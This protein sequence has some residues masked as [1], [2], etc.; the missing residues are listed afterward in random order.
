VYEHI[1]TTN[2]SNWIN[3][4][5]THNKE[6]LWLKDGRALVKFEV[7]RIFFVENNQN[8]ERRGGVGV[9]IDQWVAYIDYERAMIKGWKSHRIKFKALWKFIFCTKTQ[10]PKHWEDGSSYK[11]PWEV[12]LQ[13]MHPCQG[14]ENM[15]KQ[16]WSWWK[17]VSVLCM[18]CFV[19]HRDIH[20]PVAVACAD[21]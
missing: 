5:C 6:S 4:L 18:S 2:M 12:K 19:F 10:Q 16:M 21:A 9:S 8:I 14:E 15:K 7:L 1:T 20:R 17:F 13:A 11:K 3:G